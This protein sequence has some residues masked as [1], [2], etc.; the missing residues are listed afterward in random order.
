MFFLFSRIHSRVQDL[1]KNLPV[2][3]IPSGIRSSPQNTQDIC[4][5]IRNFFHKEI[6]FANESQKISA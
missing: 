6:V 2:W 5:T 3:K 1:Q 4:G